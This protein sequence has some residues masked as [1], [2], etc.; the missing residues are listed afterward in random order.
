MKGETI[1]LSGDMPL[2]EFVAQVYFSERD[3]RPNSQEQVRYSIIALESWA[4]RLLAVRDLSPALVNGFIADR[5]QQCGALTVKRERGDILCVWRLAH[6]HDLLTHFPYHIRK[7]KAPRRIPTAWTMDEFR[8]ILKAAGNLSG[9]YVIARGKP[10]IPRRHWWT[11]F[12]LTAYDTGLRKSDMLAL[13]RGQIRPDL[14]ICVHVAKTLVDHICRIRPETKAA[15]DATFPP[16]RQLLFPWPYSYKFV[17]YHWRQVLRLAGLPYMGLHSL[18]RTSATYLELVSPGLGGAH[19]AHI[20]PGNILAEKH[21]ID[22][23]IARALRPLPPSP[24]KPTPKP[25]GGDHV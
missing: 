7:V 6:S 13:C 20:T 15:I 9:G 21:H 25:K 14:T 1:K 19:L 23:R 24:F 5:L 2:A 11:A 18:R 4:G 17:W 8:L 12:I 16:V 10:P 22:P 3:L